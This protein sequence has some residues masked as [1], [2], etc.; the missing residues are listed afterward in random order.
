MATIKMIVTMN[1]EDDGV[2]QELTMTREVVD[3]YELCRL[4][5]DA[6]VAQGFGYVSGVVIESDNRTWSSDV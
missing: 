2:D 3:L 1:N 4:Y 5:H 6:A